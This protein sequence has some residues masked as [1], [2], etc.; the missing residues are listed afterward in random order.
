MVGMGVSGGMAVLVGMVVSVAGMLV[1]VAV[2]SLVGVLFNCFVPP[3]AQPSIIPKIDRTT[4][5]F[6]TMG[7]SRAEMIRFSYHFI[8]G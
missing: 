3:Q 4:S 2:A 7:S 5:N 6:F 1:K 8:V